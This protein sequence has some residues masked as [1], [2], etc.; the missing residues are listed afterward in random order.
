MSC[1][2]CFSPCLW[3]CHSQKGGSNQKA[4]RRGSPDF[5]SIPLPFYKHSFCEATHVSRRY[6]REGWGRYRLI[7][8]C[9]PWRFGLEPFPGVGQ[10]DTAEQHQTFDHGLQTKR[11]AEFRPWSG[12]G[13][14]GMFDPR[15]RNKTRFL[16]M[17]ER[18]IRLARVN[19]SFSIG[20]TSCAR[21]S[22][23][24]WSGGRGAAF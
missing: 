21:K 17:F 5:G 24:R 6:G 15:K 14:V 3:E 23:G 7:W 1:C 2:F 11:Q 9:R 22:G 10:L 12:L 8:E 4:N 13:W 16:C 20:L 19:A 18:Q